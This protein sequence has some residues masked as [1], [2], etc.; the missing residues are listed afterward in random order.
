MVL[1][2]LTGGISCGKSTVSKKLEEFGYVILDTD[3]IAREIVEKGTSTLRIIE[4]VFGKEILNE[5][6]TLNRKKLGDIVFNNKNQMKR[7]D[8]IMNK[9]IFNYIHRILYKNKSTEQKIVIDCAVLFEKEM[10]K[11]FN[12]DQIWVV[13]V[14]EETQLERLMMR[15]NFTKDEAL[16]RINSQMSR[17]ERLKHADVILD[18]TRDEEHLIRQ[19]NKLLNI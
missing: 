4:S 16:A 12:F 14:N 13:D 6:G 17:Q 15:N 7:L 3:K 18:N 9:S 8:S 2:G 1:I 5:D 11:E 19:I 10:D